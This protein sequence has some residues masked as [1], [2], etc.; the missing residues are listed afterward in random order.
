MSPCYRNKASHTNFN[1]EYNY[2]LDFFFSTFSSMEHNLKPNTKTQSNEISY[3]PYRICFAENG[4][5][6][7]L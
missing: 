4:N 2:F 1:T 6:D 7:D 5:G 3:E